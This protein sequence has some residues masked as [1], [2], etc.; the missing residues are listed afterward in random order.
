MHHLVGVKKHLFHLFLA[1]D[2]CAASAVVS[3]T[4]VFFGKGVDGHKSRAQAHADA[5]VRV[6]DEGKPSYAA[7]DA[8]KITHNVACLLIGE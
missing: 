8:V 4:V 6:F 7:F 5:A 2:G 3:A 1:V